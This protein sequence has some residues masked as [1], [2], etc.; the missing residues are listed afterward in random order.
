[1]KCNIR[2][3]VSCASVGAKPGQLSMQNRK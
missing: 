1:M 3:A 2:S